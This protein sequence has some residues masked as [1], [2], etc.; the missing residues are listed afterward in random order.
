MLHYE[1]IE[2]ETL[3]LLKKIQSL[4]EFR[5]MRLVGGTALALQLG[6]RK[7]VDLDFFG[8]MNCDTDELV[9]LMRG[10]GSTQLL[11]RSKSINIFIVNGIKVDFVNYDYEWIAPPIIEEDIVLAMEPDIAAMKVNAIIGRGTRKDFIDIAFLLKKYSLSQ[12]LHFYFSKYP[13]A[14]IFL[15]SKSLAYF[16]DADNDPMPFMLNEETWDEI[17]QYISSKY[18]DY[19]D[20]Y[21]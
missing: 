10:I 2:P 20:N 6:H 14:S 1:T 9:E 16:D 8:T 18:E 11:K 21:Y 17:K 19:E 13:E 15:A 4:D 3:E 12:I 5:S 7:S